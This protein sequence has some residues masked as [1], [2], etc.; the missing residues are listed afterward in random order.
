MT[1]AAQ[2]GG[3]AR[4]FG[5]A[6]YVASIPTIRVLGQDGVRGPH[7]Y[8]GSRRVEDARSC[9][10]SRVQRRSSRRREGCMGY[11][12]RCS[13][14]IG[15][16]RARS[17]GVLRSAWSRPV[18]GQHPPGGLW[19]AYG[20]GALTRSAGGA[21]ELVVSSR[22]IDGD[23]STTPE[24]DVKELPPGHRLRGRRRGAEKC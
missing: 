20:Y 15:R 3:S 7:I 13:G 19:A 21:C 6:C 12:M 1:A 9:R 4:L 5:R 16:D 23:T 17:A 18:P 24:G 2:V 8:T 22:T 11:R 10:V 14:Q